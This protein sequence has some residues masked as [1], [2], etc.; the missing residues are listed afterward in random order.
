VDISPASHAA[1]TGTVYVQYLQPYQE[2]AT[3]IVQH[4]IANIK[5]MSPTTI[6][7]FPNRP[8][9]RDNNSVQPTVQSKD[10]SS[11]NTQSVSITTGKYSGI[12]E[13]HL[14]HKSGETQTMG[15]NAW[16][17][18]P[19]SVNIKAPGFYEIMQDQL[20]GTDTTVSSN[21][22]KVHNNIS[23]TDISNLSSISCSK[24]ATELLLQAENTKLQEQMKEL[25]K[26]IKTQREENIRLTEQVREEVQSTVD[27]RIDDRMEKRFQQMMDQMVTTWTMYQTGYPMT[28]RNQGLDTNEDTSTL[29]G[30]RRIASKPKA[31]QIMDAT[32]PLEHY[33]VK[34]MVIWIKTHPTDEKHMCP[35]SFYISH[36]VVL[37]SFVPSLSLSEFPGV[38]VWF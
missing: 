12:L 26:I 17:S 8:I 4:C 30:Q 9:L 32:T 10:G 35:G 28:T 3:S 21:S 33:E 11:Y 18:I 37:E 5:E 22:S 16:R 29:Q 19:K 38:E 2:E 14:K 20:M 24:T 27:E 31:R 1:Q 34:H 23:E 7:Q 36:I 13:Q 6:V 25:Q 15:T